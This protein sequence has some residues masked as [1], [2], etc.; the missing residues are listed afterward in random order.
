MPEQIPP[1]V[2]ILSDRVHMTPIAWCVHVSFVVIVFE[3]GPKITFNLDDPEILPAENTPVIHS[4]KDTDIVPI[5]VSLV[6][7]YTAGPVGAKHVTPTST[8]RSTS[9]GVNK[10]K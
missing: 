3:Q 5:T 7:P 8:R 4:T 10:P 6:S 9:R 2:Q 1:I